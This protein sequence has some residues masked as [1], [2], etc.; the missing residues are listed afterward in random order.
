MNTKTSSHIC[1]NCNTPLNGNYCIVCGQKSTVSK[2]TIKETL[3]D[4]LDMFFSVNAPLM[5]TLKYLCIN[6]GKVFR[7]FIQGKRKTYYKPVP[8][9]ILMTVLY[10]LMSSILNTEALNPGFR[11]E[12]NIS[13]EAEKLLSRASMFMQRNITNFLFLFVLTIGISLKTLFRKRYT[14]AE[15]FAIAFYFVGMYTLMITCFMYFINKLSA[16]FRSIPLILIALYFIYVVISLFKEW[17]LKTILK[18]IMAYALAVILFMLCS[19]GVS[20]LIVFLNL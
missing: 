12:T 5:V 13:I 15:Y 19:F 8:F 14:L 2:I 16:S 9:F 18:G 1:K 6:P 4:I 7:E 10:V 11:F 20:T 3:Q 17:K